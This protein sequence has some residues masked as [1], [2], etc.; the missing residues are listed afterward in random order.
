MSNVRWQRS[1]PNQPIVQGGAGFVL[2]GL[3]PGP[4]KFNTLFSSR[5]IGTVKF[6]FLEK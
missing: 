6:G 2:K 1:I 5:V 3:S 4:R